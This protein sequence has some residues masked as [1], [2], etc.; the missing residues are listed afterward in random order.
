MGGDEGV[1]WQRKCGEGAGVRYSWMGG[2][3]EL[4]V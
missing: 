1:A 3:V 4:D 2:G